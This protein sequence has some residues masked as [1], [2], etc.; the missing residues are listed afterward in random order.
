MN[1]LSPT[2][3]LAWIRL[4]SAAALSVYV[5]VQ[6]W[7]EWNQ[8]VALTAIAAYMAIDKVLGVAESK[9]TLD[10]KDKEEIHDRID[11]AFEDATK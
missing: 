8:T 9:F 2:N 11:A 10:K 3:I 7:I 4:V 5:L 1:K 6:A